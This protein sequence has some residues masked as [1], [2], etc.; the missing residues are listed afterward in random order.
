MNGAGGNNAQNSHNGVD[1]HGHHNHHTHHGAAGSSGEKVSNSGRETNTNR[2]ETAGS[3]IINPTIKVIDGVV[4]FF[5]GYLIPK[6]C[7]LTPYL[8]TCH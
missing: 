4:T 2:S 3:L 7:P 5:K 8:P 1:K 6:V